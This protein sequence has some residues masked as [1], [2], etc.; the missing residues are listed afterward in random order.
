MFSTRFDT[1]HIA[2]IG[3]A[4]IG[5]DMPLTKIFDIDLNMKVSPN[6]N[7]MIKKVT[8]MKNT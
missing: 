7:E 4:K 5:M 1:K 2:K 8:I 3:I 6:I